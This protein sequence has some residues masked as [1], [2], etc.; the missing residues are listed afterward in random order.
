MAKLCRGYVNKIIHNREHI[1]DKHKQDN[2]L[3]I[4]L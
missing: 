3:M 4:K 2:G 1:K